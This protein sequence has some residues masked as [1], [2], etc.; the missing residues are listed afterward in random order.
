MSTEYYTNDK[1]ELQIPVLQYGKLAIQAAQQ[2]VDISKLIIRKAADRRK[3]EN[4]HSTAAL[5]PVPAP[6]PVTCPAPAMFP[7]P[8]PVVVN[9]ADPDLNLR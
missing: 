5:P 1:L 6:E 7:T 9:G 8:A 2:G 3:G 4:Y